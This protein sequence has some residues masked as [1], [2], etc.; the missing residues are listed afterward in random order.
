M[1]S[2]VTIIVALLVFAVMV[3][4]H[5]FGHFITAKLF[6]INVVEF[7]VGMGPA[8]FKKKYKETTYALRCIPLGGYC[9]FDDDVGNDT[10]PNSFENAARY[11][12][13]CVALAGAF[14][15][16]IL[17]FLI[18][19]ILQ[20]ANMT[21]YRPVITGFVEQTNLQAAGL[22]TGDKILRLNNTQIHIKEDIDFFMQR[23]GD[24][25]VLVTAKRDGKTLQATVTPVK[26]QYVYTYDTDKITL[27]TIVG[28]T[29]ISQESE[30]A[31]SDTDYQNYVGQTASITKYLLGFQ[32]TNIPRSIG[33][34]LYDAFYTTL[35][36]IKI[37]Y[38]SLWDLL[39]GKVGADQVSGPIGI[40]SVIGQA[41]QIGWQPLL[42]LVGL[43]TVNLGI[44]N[45][46][47]IPGLDGCK[48]LTLIA[49]GITRRKLPKKVE[50][51]ITLIGFGLLILLMLWA[52]F[53]DV[54]N[55]FIK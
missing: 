51:V 21:T 9:M 44:M 32:G 26:T 14:L 20:S 48:A 16:L 19:V 22:Q 27:T 49:E 30:P 11:K 15:N 28:G 5:E 53:N 10:S 46:L 1:S 12:R 25:P 38:V 17:G 43:L 24:A 6:K 36:N 45:L 3:V 54:Q 39:L 8:L 47:P 18:F 4:V 13:L 37:V 55:L 42:S 35:Y 7:A 52:T 40:V 29:Q 31:P 41:T 2:L 50:T 23:N 33:S 34:V